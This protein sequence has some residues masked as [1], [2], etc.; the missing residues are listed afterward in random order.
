MM[1]S[2]AR[3][4]VPT[5]V[6]NLCGRLSLLTDAILVAA[7]LGP[8][9]VTRLYL[10]QRLVAVG[11]T[12]LLGLSGATWAGL[13]ELHF[14]NRADALARRLAQ[15]T[16]LTALAWAAVVL[17]T[18]VATHAFLALWV[19]AEFDA[20]S[21]VVVLAAGNALVVALFTLWT[22]PLQA[23]GFVRSVVPYAL[24]STALN[25]GV[26]LFATPRWGVIGPLL[27]TAVA[28][29]VVQWWWLLLLLRAHL[30]V[31]AGPLLSAAVRP[32][33]A[34]ALY[35]APWVWL[36]VTFPPAELMLPAWAKWATLLGGTAVAAGG[37]LVLA[38]FL[39]LPREERAEL[40]ARLLGR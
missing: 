29:L 40:R 27:G 17:P 6:C 31:P 18:A 32:L 1:A 12:Q 38:W 26:G 25:L 24:V 35:Y 20:G 22:W 19:G 2:L 16:G 13:A 8:V 34:A 39:V 5:F 10:T 3:L 11:G 9:A 7:F 37:Y 33:P 4:S 14:Q 15:I 28:G 30:K 23:C 36:A 21:A